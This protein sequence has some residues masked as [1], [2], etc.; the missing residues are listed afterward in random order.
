LLEKPY[1][2]GVLSRLFLSV[3]MPSIAVRD[4]AVKWALDRTAW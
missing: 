1:G 2:S 3:P 4:L